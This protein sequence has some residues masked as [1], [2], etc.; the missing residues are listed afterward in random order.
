MPIPSSTMVSV[1][2]VALARRG[3]E[4]ALRVGVARVAQ[5]LDDDVLEAPDVVLCL[6]AFGLGHAQTH[7]AVAERLLDFEVAVAGDRGDEVYEWVVSRSCRPPA[8]HANG[9]GSQD[10]G[11]RER[12]P[13]R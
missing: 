11:D 12:S 7:V 5:E 1:R 2:M 3:D 9:A 10:R 4:D 13:R 8:C 6:P